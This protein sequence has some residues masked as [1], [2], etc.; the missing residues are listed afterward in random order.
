MR[1]RTP[2]APP[3][4]IVAG[5]FV[6]LVGVV[7]S[8]CAP[9]PSLGGC[10]D[11]CPSD[12]VCRDNVCVDPEAS[13]SGDVDD[14]ATDAPDSD[15][16][17]DVP[18]DGSDTDDVEDGDAVDSSDGDDADATDA[19]DTGDTSDTDDVPD[20][21]DVVD[22]TGTDATDAD[23]TDTGVD[24]G[25]GEGEVCAT[26]DQ[27]SW[28][29]QCDGTCQAIQTWGPT[30]AMN[31][32]GQRLGAAVT[33]ANRRIVVGAPA[34]AGGRG[35]VY[36]TMLVGDGG[37][38]GDSY[39]AIAP[40]V[41]S[42]D[43]AFGTAVATDGVDVAVG[44]PGD[45]SEAANG[46]AAY[47]IRI[48]RIDTSTELFAS[49]EFG[50]ELGSS[51]GTGSLIAAGVPGS[52]QVLHAVPARDGG[53]VDSDVLEPVP[54][55]AAWGR[56]MDVKAPIALVSNGNAVD[57][58]TLD[59]WGRIAQPLTEALGGGVSISADRT[60]AAVGCPNHGR[61]PQVIVLSVTGG[62]A[63]V[64][65]RIEAPEGY[66][67][68]GR[69]IG[70]G[71]G[72]LAIGAHHDSSGTDVVVVYAFRDDSWSVEARLA[73]PG[74]PG[75]EFGHDAL[76]VA[77]DL[78]IVGDPGDPAFGGNFFVYNMCR[79][80]AHGPSCEFSCR[81]G[82]RNGSET[83][84]SC[85]G[86]ICGPCTAAGDACLANGDCEPPLAC[87]GGQCTAMEGGPEAG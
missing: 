59:G 52:S 27:C 73:N 41:G 70:I 65:D 85:G 24:I 83:D 9:V 23:A 15:V 60:A 56:L 50:D 11:D 16:D 58:F 67:D 51:V 6:V 62:T 22:D 48:R 45:S 80:D 68:W 43:Q 31:V 20:A 61:G 64:A 55:R 78:V 47:L 38:P 32:D 28:N 44:A 4:A 1:H 49:G 33:L 5:W 66:T 21:G 53:F 63:E 18:R 19:P 30:G 8:G 10:F 37:A 79:G 82:V 17:V 81:D 35:R 36:S 42:G 40:T 29:L 76:D 87:E 46:G 74:V 69:S 57:F 26:G 25:L 2:L 71:D 86:D 34:H 3:P 84:A 39:E 75:S 14:D 77:G 13:S 72:R 54:S 12:W 7:S